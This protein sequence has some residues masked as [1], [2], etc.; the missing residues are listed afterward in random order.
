MIS[1]D[2]HMESIGAPC[3]DLPCA[4]SKMIHVGMPLGKV[5]AAVTTAP[6]AAIGW[7]DRIGS[8]EVPFREMNL[9]DS[10]KFEQT[11]LRVI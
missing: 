2:L 7:E 10:C 11:T 1:T 9:S 6:A 8:L 5:I 4:M 3:Y